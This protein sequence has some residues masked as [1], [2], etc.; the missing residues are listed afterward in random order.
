MTIAT[1]PL[2]IDK[3]LTGSA[4]SAAPDEFLA[5]V[6]CTVAGAPVDLGTLGPVGAREVDGLHGAHRRHPR[7][8]RVHDR[9]SGRPGQLRRGGA[10]RV[11]RH[12][13]DRSCRR[14]RHGSGAQVATITNTYEFGQLSVAKTANTAAVDERGE[15]TY[16]ITVANTGALDA[17]DF[18][19]TDTLPAG[20]TYV[21]SSAG[22]TESERRRHLAD[23]R[24]QEGRPDR[25]A[26]RRC[27]S[28]LRATS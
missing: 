23:R 13:D 9:R 27:P 17:K 5:D 16:T 2:Q 6:A 19:V 4:A 8:R 18:D 21:S 15:V 3:Q 28:R 12:D 20:S 1:G 11:A 7:R 24:A 10:I 22:G 14:R 25:A 26:G